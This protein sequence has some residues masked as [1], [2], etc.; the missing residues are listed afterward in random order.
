MRSVSKPAKC[1]RGPRVGAVNRVHAMGSCM[2][3]GG[4]QEGPSSTLLSPLL[5]FPSSASAVLLAFN[6]G[7]KIFVLGFF[8]VG[9]VLKIK[10]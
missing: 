10:A 6:I 5:R 9:T 4:R 2:A 8:W 7:L 1:R 3:V